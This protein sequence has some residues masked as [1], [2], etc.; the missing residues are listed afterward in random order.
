MNTQSQSRKN[1]PVDQR[2]ADEYG[3]L[4]GKF[5]SCNIGSID[6]VRVLK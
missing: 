4:Q 2:K 1:Y 3:Q 6:V 5:N